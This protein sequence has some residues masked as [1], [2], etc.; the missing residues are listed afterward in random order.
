MMQIAVAVLAGNLL[1]NLI[2]YWAVPTF[3][4]HREE[5][6][7]E[8]RARAHCAIDPGPGYELKFYPR[9]GCLA[10]KGEWARQLERAGVVGER[11]YK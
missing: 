3:K 4:A 7:W 9:A 11:L 10:P 2:C 5:R 8:A 1:G 6:A